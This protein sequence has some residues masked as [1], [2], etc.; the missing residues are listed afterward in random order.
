MD[1][2]INYVKIGSPPQAEKHAAD[3]ASGCSIGRARLHLWCEA[4]P[5]ASA[6]LY[7]NI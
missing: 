4:A 5:G 2:G 7:H 6:D 3:A 1:I